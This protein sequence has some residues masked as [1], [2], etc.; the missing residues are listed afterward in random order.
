[1]GSMVV[2]PFC[3]STSYWGLFL[4]LHILA[5]MCLLSSE[6]LVLAILIG[7]RWNLRVVLI[8]ISLMTKDFE[9][10]FK[11][12]SGIGDNW[13]FHCCE[14]SVWCYAPPLFFIRYL[15]YLNFKCYLLFQFPPTPGNPL[16]H[17]P[18]TC[19][20]EGVPPL[21][22]PLPPPHPWFP[23]TGTSIKPS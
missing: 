20:Y 5:S 18:S 23:Y 12:F 21:T 15:L 17:P 3:N 9:H 7:V 14:F 19:F 13:R 10:F 22:H 2:V 6:V 8:C 16:S 1:M 11:C 4:F